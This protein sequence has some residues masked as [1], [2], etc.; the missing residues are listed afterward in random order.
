[1]SAVLQSESQPILLRY[2]AGKAF[3]SGHD[4]KQMRANHGKEYKHR[5][6]NHTFEMYLRVWQP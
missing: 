2:D 3:C 4:L 6:S 1:M 5:K